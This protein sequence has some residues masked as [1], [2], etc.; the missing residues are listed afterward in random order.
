MI[1][2]KGLEQ[3]VA[4]RKFDICDAVSS[5]LQSKRRLLEVG[6]STSKG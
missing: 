3:K 4:E 2:Q 1:K 5:E 6:S